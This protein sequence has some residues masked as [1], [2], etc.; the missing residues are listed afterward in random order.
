MFAAEQGSPVEQ[1]TLPCFP[2]SATEP[3]AVALPGFPRLEDEWLAELATNDNP[4]LALS[5]ICVLATSGSDLDPQ[6]LAL[7]ACV[8]LGADAS[9]DRFLQRPELAE[10]PAVA[11]LAWL[12]AVAGE[13]D[14]GAF[15][16]DGYARLA[17]SRLRF[18]ATTLMTAWAAD[19]GPH[20][21]RLR[22]LRVLGG[23]TTVGDSRAILKAPEQH[24][25][26]EVSG[27]ELALLG[28]LDRITYLSER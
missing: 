27:C 26:R 28:A 3:K 18:L 19:L 16:A 21:V 23:R 12:I 9:V 2:E 25:Q 4:D 11:Y 7:R 17:R 13:D 24:V 20:Q 1:P 15:P 14:P 8:A 6:P 5:A 22:D 10:D